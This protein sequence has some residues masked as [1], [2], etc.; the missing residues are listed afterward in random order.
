MKP[1]SASTPK[2]VEQD[3]R[4][5]FAAERTLLAWI[6]TGLA[7][8]GFGFV[9]ARFGLFIA[10]LTAARAGAGQIPADSSRGRVSLAIGVVLVVTGVVMNLLS[11]MS[12]VRTMRRLRDGVAITPNAWSAATMLALLMAALGAAMACYLLFVH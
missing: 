9:V 10:E 5:I 4:V 11:T 6:R 7:L 1:D 8:M 12:H 3:P 2:T